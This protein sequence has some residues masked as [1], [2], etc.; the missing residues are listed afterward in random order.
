MAMMQASVL[1][2]HFGSYLRLPRFVS[3]SHSL[4]GSGQPWKRQVRLTK[5]S[6]RMDETLGYCVLS[7]IR[8]VADLHEYKVWLL[9]QFGVLHDGKKPYPGA[10]EALEML[11]KSGVEL[12]LLSNSSRRSEV[13]TEKLASLGFDP[14]IFSGILTSGEL[15]HRYL[16]S[17]QDPWFSALG[18][19]CIHITWSAR[20]SISLEGLGLE[21]VEDLEQADF[22]L[23][24]GTEALGKRDG[25]NVEPVSLEKLELLL[26]IASMRHIPMIIANPDLVTVETR[27]LRTMPG[28]LGMKY[29]QMGGEVRWMGKPDPIIY[30]AV[31]EITSVDAALTVAVGDSLHH[32]IR[33]ASSSGIDSVFV[34]GGIHAQE[35]LIDEIGAPPN[36]Q[37]LLS[38]IHNEGICPSYVIPTFSW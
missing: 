28:T 16:E 34:A 32:D 18:Q 33:G 2:Q 11:A 9:D 38:L 6:L 14:S 25:Y 5:A 20:G 21:I 8:Q 10:V 12:V 30:R 7:G 17:R 26:Q 19:R 31:E 36:K 35:L 27:V 23:A 22:I 37:A 3:S 24:H 13:T 15:T 4:A 29:E 1:S